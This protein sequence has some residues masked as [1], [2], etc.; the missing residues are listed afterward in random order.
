MGMEARGM[1]ILSKERRSHSSFASVEHRN[2]DDM[3][4]GND[5]KPYHHIQGTRQAAVVGASIAVNSM[6]VDKSD[7]FEDVNVGELM[8]P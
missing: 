5:N 6:S 2:N 4:H 3:Q 8:I 1:E 7:D